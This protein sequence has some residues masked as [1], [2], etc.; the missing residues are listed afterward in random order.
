[1]AETLL[2]GMLHKHWDVL[3][4]VGAI[5]AGGLLVDRRFDLATRGSII[6]LATHLIGYPV[7]LVVECLR[8]EFLNAWHLG[9][10][11]V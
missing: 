8:S 1:M 9:S 7:Q 2:N 5:E 10:P 4:D 6:E 3:L 11:Y